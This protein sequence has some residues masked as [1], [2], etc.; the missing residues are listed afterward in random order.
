MKKLILLIL[1]IISNL[2]TFSQ[3]TT[4]KDTT[5]II[6]TKEVAREVVKDLIR[7]EGLE[8]ENNILLQNISLLQKNSLLKDSILFYKDSVISF[9]RQ[10]DTNYVNLLTFKDQQIKEYKKLSDD[11]YSYSKKVNTK[12]TLNNILGVSFVAF[13]ITVLAVK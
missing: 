5:Q 3:D 10:K 4:N 13:L 6:L 7:K 9:Y 11:L 2:T 12:L 8:K 1:I